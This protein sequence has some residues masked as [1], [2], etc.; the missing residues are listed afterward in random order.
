MGQFD[1]RRPTGI[2]WRLHD[3][4]QSL[5]PF[6]VNQDLPALVAG[7]DVLANGVLCYLVE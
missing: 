1:G 6:H 7:L 3:R 4:S 2:G 5:S